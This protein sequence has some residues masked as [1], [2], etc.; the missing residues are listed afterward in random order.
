MKLRWGDKSLSIEESKDKIIDEI[1]FF[2][3]FYN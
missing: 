1:N 3:I 2:N